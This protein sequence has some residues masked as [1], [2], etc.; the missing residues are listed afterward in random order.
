MLT[1]NPGIY[2]PGIRLFFL[3]EFGP[4]HIGKFP[5]T[6]YGMYVLLQ[7]I[8]APPVITATT[9]VIRPRTY[10]VW[11]IISILW[12]CPIIG[13]MALIYS[14]KVSVCLSHSTLL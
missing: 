12:L 14:L 6:I 2:I 11:S 3:G 1:I 13:I 10:M 7:V 5:I 9:L 4:S 8:T